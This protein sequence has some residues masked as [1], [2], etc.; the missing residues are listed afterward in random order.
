MHYTFWPESGHNPVCSCS[1]TELD[2]GP[3][4]INE[5][6]SLANYVDI[7]VSTL[8]GN[9]FNGPKISL[10]LSKFHWNLTG[11]EWISNFTFGKP[12]CAT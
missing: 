10:F 3:A 2:S 1:A 7:L 8:L 12:E 6:D 5:L 11:T 9:F 4:G